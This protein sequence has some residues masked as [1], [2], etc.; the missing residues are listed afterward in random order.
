MMTTSGL[1]IT[2]VTLWQLFNTYMSHEL[3]KNFMHIGATTL[4]IIV[5]THV[6]VQVLSITVAALLI[7]FATT[8][9]SFTS[10]NVCYNPIGGN[11]ASRICNTGI[12]TSILS[13]I[14]ILILLLFH[15]QRPCLIS[16]VSWTSYR[17]EYVSTYFDSN[18]QYAL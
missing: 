9:A 3:A 18:I 2:Y 1:Y 15:L 4:V 11:K 14:M 13:S 6:Y 12:A 16:P 10:I 8:Y 7:D 17:F 5:C